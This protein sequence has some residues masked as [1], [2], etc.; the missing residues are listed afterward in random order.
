MKLPLRLTSQRKPALGK[1]LFDLVTAGSALVVLA[2]PLA[3]VAMII[4]CSSR[5]PVMFKQQRVGQFGRS[6]RL[7]KF[8]TMQLAVA[9]TEVTTEGDRRIYPV[10][11]WL[12]RWKIDELPQ[13]WNIVRGEMSMIGPRP[14][15][16]RFVGH[17]TAEQRRVL[18]S[19][20][21]LA[22]MAQ[23][24]YPYEAKLLAGVSDPERTYLTHLMPRKV[25]ADLAYERTRSFWSDLKLVAELALL[26]AGKSYRTD[27]SLRVGSSDARR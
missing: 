9:G 5:G 19:K 13:L 2:L 20:P 7:Y 8:R 27:T 24:M 18:D 10:G 16:P 14:E 1:R 22:S 15:V 25:A 23:L 17:Y 12:R 3:I 4:K 6:F 11:R 26:V 21:G